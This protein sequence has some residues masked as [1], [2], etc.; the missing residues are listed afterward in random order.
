MNSPSS[1]VD[2]S[3]GLSIY[4]VCNISSKQ[5]R[6]GRKVIMEFKDALSPVT[7]T[8]GLSEKNNLA[9]WII[10]NDKKAYKT[11]ELNK[12]SFLDKE[13]LI[14]V[15]IYENQKGKFK[16]TLK[17]YYD[18]V[19]IVCEALLNL[20]GE[21]LMEYSVGAT[22]LGTENAAFSLKELIL[23]SIIDEKENLNSI[24]QY[25]DKKHNLNHV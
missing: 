11:D 23:R 10:D 12:D 17:S 1:K 18:G 14:L 16:I 21:I 8:I 4:A 9:A 6:Q 19:A 5:K 13:T 20:T 24:V 22:V 15:S 7:L 3:K 2:L 25:L